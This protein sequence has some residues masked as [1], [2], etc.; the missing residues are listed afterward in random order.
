MQYTIAYHPL[1]V[2]IIVYFV[3][4]VLHE[5]GKK[6]QSVPPALRDSLF[7]LRIKFL[8]T[9]STNLQIVPAKEKALLFL[10]FGLLLAELIMNISQKS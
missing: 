6:K 2:F 5:S 1:K 3:C 9:S 10:S 7:Y 8:V 4:F